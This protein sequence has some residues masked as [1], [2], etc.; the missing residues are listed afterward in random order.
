M[1]PF[2]E[3]LFNLKL[4]DA[5]KGLHRDTNARLKQ[6]DGDQKKIGQGYGP[7]WLAK[8]MDAAIDVFHK[9]YV[10]KVDKACRETWLSDH[11][12]VTPEFIR[13][14]LVP[15]VLAFVA[16]R[17][18]AIQGETVLL[19]GRTGI[20]TGLTP[21]LHHLVHEI[22]R[23]QG[24]LA[25]RYEIEAIELGKPTMQKRRFTQAPAPPTPI[26]G[27]GLELH[28]PKPT[29]VPG[30]PPTYFPSDLWPQTN[31]IL[32]KAQRMFL[33]QTQTLELCK[34]VVSEMTPLFIEAVK[35]GRMKA[36]NVLRDHGG[37]MEDM[38]QLLLLRN[39]PGPNSGWGLSNQGNRL[40]QEVRKSDEWLRLG[41]AIAE[42]H[43]GQANIRA[44]LPKLGELRDVQLT[45]RRE[46]N[47]RSWLVEHG[48]A[49]TA[50]VLASFAQDTSKT[51]E[52]GSKPTSVLLHK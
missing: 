47:L 41:E 11:D 40:G 21:A 4:Q 32:L 52:A 34:H 33:T 36:A 30:N 17:K 23:V 22:S 26:R 44:R 35:T 20:G 42:A 24:D 10:P 38:L 29:E 2:D 39:D 7:G 12:A 14:I 1:K 18:G 37:G 50:E 48:I 28:Q 51:A 27:L 8:R 45:E 43:A 5:C 46:H 19:A 13:G 16:A 15:R 49:P 3:G 31:V 6:V 25:K 9:D